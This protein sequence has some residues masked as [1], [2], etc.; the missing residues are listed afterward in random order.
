[1][2][3]QECPVKPGEELVEIGDATAQ[4]ILGEG[5]MEEWNHARF[6]TGLDIMYW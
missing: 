5:N 3:V 2:L 4:L 6:L 1:M